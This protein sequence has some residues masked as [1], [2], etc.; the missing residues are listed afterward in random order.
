LNAIPSQLT[1]KCVI[2]VDFSEYESIDYLKS[3]A[4]IYYVY[5]RDRN[6]GSRPAPMILS[7]YKT[8]MEILK[9]SLLTVEAALPLGA[10]DE[11]SDDRWGDDFGSTWRER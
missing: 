4:A 10:L 2:L 9:L 1:Q 7:S 8:H 6:R 3:L 11:D 5:E